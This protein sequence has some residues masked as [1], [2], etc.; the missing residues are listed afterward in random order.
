MFG[1]RVV[2]VISVV[3]YCV[4]LFSLIWGQR[5]IIEYK[6]SVEQNKTLE[7][8]IADLDEQN[9]FISREIRL[10]QSDE[11][12]VEKVIRN[13]LHFIRDNE[14]RYIFPDEPEKESSGALPNEAKN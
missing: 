1:L 7:G 8:R 6:Q 10:L 12:Y 9:I 4:L 2:L 13:R 11:K 5:G 14:I 3:L